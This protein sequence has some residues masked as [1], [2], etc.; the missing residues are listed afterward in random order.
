MTTLCAWCEAPKQG[1]DICPSCGADYA[2]AEAIKKHGRVLTASDHHADFTEPDSNYNSNSSGDSPNYE[3][4]VGDEQYIDDPHRERLIC[5]YALPGMLFGAWLV[6][7]LGVFDGLQSIVFGMPL[8]ELGHASAAWLLGYNA[9]PTLWKTVTFSAGW[10]CPTL[11]FLSIGLVANYGRQK[12]RPAWVVFALVLWLI[13][14]VFFFGFDR[15]TEDMLITFAGD[16]GGMILASGLMLL[17][18]VGKQTQ[19]YQ[20]AVRW[21]LLF[22]GAAA[23]MD[24]F[25]PWWRGQYDIRNI[26]YGMTG[27]MYSDAF[28]LINQHGWSWD[29]MISRHL[30]VA[31]TCMVVLAVGYYFGLRQSAVWIKDKARTDRI[32]KARQQQKESAKWTAGSPI[33]APT[34]EPP[35]PITGPNNDSSR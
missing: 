13:Q 2:K 32:L 21:G 1:G 19:L 20:G 25:M 12:E 15:N 7:W 3:T 26:G 5:W 16:A 14:G 23:F 31:Y 17:F 11:V 9:I 35:E 8:H 29:A 30:Q 33:A 4:I 18:Y 27:G 22:I 28:L 6:Q 24:M 34:F 10:L